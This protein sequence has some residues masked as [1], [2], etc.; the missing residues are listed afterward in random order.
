[1]RIPIDEPMVVSLEGEVVEVLFEEPD[2][3][4]ELETQRAYE[5]VRNDPWLGCD[6]EP[7]TAHHLDVEVHRGRRSLCNWPSHSKWSV[8]NFGRDRIDQHTDD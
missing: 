7:V 4:P 6:D 2:H 8:D 3:E 5:A 1:M